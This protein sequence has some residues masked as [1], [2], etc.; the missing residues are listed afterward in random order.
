[1]NGNRESE[2]TGSG[3]TASG[4]TSDMTFRLFNS[5]ITGFDI[6]PLCRVEGDDA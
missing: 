6:Q 1:M 5:T 4:C 2:L 3:T